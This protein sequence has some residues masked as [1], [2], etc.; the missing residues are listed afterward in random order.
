MALL[1]MIIYFQGLA[2]VEAFRHNVQQSM[3]RRGARDELN[4]GTTYGHLEGQGL[5]LQVLGG[6]PYLNNLINNKM[7]SK[8]DHKI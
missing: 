2:R 3:I 4:G 5:P 6:V 8:A 7:Q 1:F